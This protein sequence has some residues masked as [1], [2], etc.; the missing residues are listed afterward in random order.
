LQQQP[1]EESVQQLLTG[2][3]VHQQPTGVSVQQLLTG[4]PV[5]QQQTGEAVQQQLTGVS[6][7]QQPTGES[8]PAGDPEI[9]VL[10]CKPSQLEL[11]T[12]TTPAAAWI[13][14]TLLLLSYL[15]K[16]NGNILS[17]VCELSMN[18][19]SHR[20][21]AYSRRIMIFCLTLAGYSVKAYNYLRTTAQHC[22]PCMNTIRNYRQRVDGSPG[23]STSALN[24]I[25]RKVKEME[26]QSKKLFTSVSCDDMSIRQ[27]IWFT[28]KTFYGH[29]DIGD[30]PGTKLATHVM[31]IMA[32]ALNMS[33]KVPVGYFL[34]PDGFKAEKRAELLR[35]AV[36]H[37]NNTGVIVTN[38]VMDNCPVNYATFKLLGCNLS[39]QLYDLNTETELQNVS[40]K[41]VLALFDPPHL[42]KLGNCIKLKGH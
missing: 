28:G 22:L 27:H 7:Q 35:T 29:E 42:S 12:G 3:S 14:T 18:S 31:L 40:G 39:R 23:F 37:L 13:L 11:S 32:T 8:E 17:E 25:S 34:I 5:Q 30:G 4:V 20:T 15:Q 19:S 6:V 10:T 41:H 26:E 9:E 1:T 21:K 24:M 2:V 16:R 33:W 38:I 36:Y